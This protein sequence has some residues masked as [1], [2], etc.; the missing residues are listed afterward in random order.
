MPFESRPIF[1][2]V[3][4]TALILAAAAYSQDTAASQSDAAFQKNVAS[5]LA[6]TFSP[7]HNSQF[8]SGGLNVANF[9]KRN[10]VA[11]NRD[12]W[13]VIV[14]RTPTAPMPTDGIRRPTPSKLDA[15]LQQVESGCAIADRDIK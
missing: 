7:C 14:H 9:Q 4:V 8:A 2:A 5:V 3:V 10:P 15:L 6:N 12:A 1:V 11:G 13:E